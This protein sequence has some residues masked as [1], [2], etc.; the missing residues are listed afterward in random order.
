MG[1]VLDSNSKPEAYRVETVDDTTTQSCYN[2][3]QQ[4]RV[5]SPESKSKVSPVLAPSLQIWTGSDNLLLSSVSPTWEDKLTE[6]P[7]IH[8]PSKSFETPSIILNPATD[9]TRRRKVYSGA[10]CT[11]PEVHTEAIPTELVESHALKKSRSNASKPKFA[12]E[13]IP[14]Q[15]LTIVGS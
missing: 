13:P 1:S 6:T 8:A 12:I 3:P 4:T 2:S 10:R 5:S 15:T 11:G 9:K 14:T 7:V